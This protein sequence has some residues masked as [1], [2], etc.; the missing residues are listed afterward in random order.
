VFVAAE[1]ASA[2]AGPIKIIGTS[3]LGEKEVTREARY[4]VVVWGSPNR[5]Q[6]PAQF[7]LAP[8]LELG[9]IDKELE[10]ALVQVGE[11]RVYVTALGGKLELPIKAIRRDGFS[12]AI[13]LTAVGLAQPMRPKDVTLEGG[14]NEAKLEIA[15]A[16][17]NIRP[18]SY[19]FYLKGETKHKYARQTGALAAAEA[20]QT[21][22]A[23]LV[24]KLKDE[25]KS[26]QQATHE[27]NRNAAEARL[28][29]A[30]Q[31]KTAADKR[32]AD[33][34]QARQAAKDVPLA[35]VSTP[36]QLRVEA[37]P[38]KIAAGPA[39]GP[40]APGAKQ[41]LAVK[42]ERLY[43][44]AGDVEL[45][46]EPAEGAKGLAASKATVAKDQTETKLEIAAATDAPAGEQSLTLRARGKNNGVDVETRTTVRVTVAGK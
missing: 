25:V 35:L 45:A 21:R 30:E 12:E 31:L 15:L 14:K 17:Q 41:P 6:Q 46:L 44:F 32:V 23:E 13:K 29:E 10:P 33:L 36:V 18:G 24:G 26:A 8:V 19:T 37:S 2:W 42:I 28:K 11:G 4:A 43:G 27:A 3:R 20:E 39:A 34:K 22:L 40:I 9:V 16:Q 5:Q 1:D 7:R 38:I